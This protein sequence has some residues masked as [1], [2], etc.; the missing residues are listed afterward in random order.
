[1]LP[2][3]LAIARPNRTTWSIHSFNKHQNLKFDEIAQQHR[4]KIDDMQ[5]FSAY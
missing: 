3:R 2:K 5:S 4:Y 1:M